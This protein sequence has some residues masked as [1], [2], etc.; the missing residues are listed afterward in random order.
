VLSL[1]KT[2]HRMHSVPLTLDEDEVEA[3][4]MGLGVAIHH[5]HIHHHK[6]AHL[7][8][9]HPT[10]YKK[11]RASH[12]KGKHHLLKFKKGEGFWDAVKSAGKKLIQHHAPAVAERVGHHVG[13]TLGKITAEKLGY[14]AEKG[15]DM[16]ARFGAHF[17]HKVGHHIAHNMGEGLRHHKHLRTHHKHSVAGGAV[18]RATPRIVAPSPAGHGT[19]QL[20]SPYACANS[21][22]MHPY[23]SNVNQ[24]GG[25]NP[26][27]SHRG[28]GK[29]ISGGSFSPVGGSGLHHHHGH[30]YVSL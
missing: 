18:V 3:L 20:G 26:L 2:I 28:H 29:E 6:G 23:F 1:A 16:G 22:Q 25:Y 14:D 10:T 11:L 17:G 24:N 30:R 15:A 12:A 27:R 7:V 8:L 19:I 13:S 4:S 5:H 21:P 9:L